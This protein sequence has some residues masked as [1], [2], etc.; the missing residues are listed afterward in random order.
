MNIAGNLLIGHSARRGM[1]GVT[2]AIDAST[3]ERMEPAFGG[4]T[5]DD[6][7]T[8]C[9][10]AW[11]AF[12]RYRETSLEARAQFLEAIA[13]NILELGDALVERCVAESG[14]PRARVEG[15]R[16]RT[17]GQL[18]MFAG[19]VRAGD[20][21]EARIDPAQPERKPLPRPDLRLRHI[22][23]GPVAVFGAS[24]FPLAFSVAGG[25]TASA[26]AAGCPVIVK[27]HSAHPGTSELVGLAVQ[28]AVKDC[29]MPEGTFSLL[30]GSGV[31]IG[32]GL[33]RDSRIKAVG[34]TGSRHAGTALV[35]IANARPEPV[36]VYAEMSS[37]NPVLLFPHALQQRGVEIAQAF[38]QSLTLGAGQFCTNPGLILAVDGPALDRFIAA[39]A[40]RLAQAPAAT[41]LTPGIHRAFETSVS[42]FVEHPSVQTVARAHVPTGANQGQGALFSTT[43]EA[44]RE[45]VELHEEIFGASSL[46]VRCPDLKT[47]LA[48]IESLEGQLTAAL[49]IDDADHDAVRSFLPALE[50]RAGRILVNGFGTGVEVGHAMVHGGPYPSTADGRSTSVGSLAIRRFLRPVSYQDMPDGLLPEALKKG[51]AWAINRLLDGRIELAK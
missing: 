4:A 33:V 31:E 6:L 26:L 36:P 9:A 39:A 18:R 51:N 29:G 8:A 45:C 35:A 22:G 3:G 43:A 40:E 49:H 34:L 16:G 44:F 42:K 47:M 13:S 12:D 23:L 37:I 50:R 27:A 20:F 14:L 46:V 7:E 21:I 32:Q 48:L 41:M 11:A 19:V 5:T 15:E 28:K 2:Y 38:V 25:D 24:N 1:S 30:F 10:L 17:V